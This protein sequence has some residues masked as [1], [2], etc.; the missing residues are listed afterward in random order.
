MNYKNVLVAAFTAGSL[1]IPIGGMAGEVAITKGML[2]VDVMHNG[3]KVTIMR[4]QDQKNTVIPAFA[5]P[6]GNALRSASN[7]RPWRRAWR[8][9][10]RSR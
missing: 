9:S 1:M 7:R 3:K 4:N 2:S 5:K 10:A 6:P 8:P